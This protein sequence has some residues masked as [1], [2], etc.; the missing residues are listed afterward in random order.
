MAYFGKYETPAELL[1]DESLNKEKKIE[2]LEQW[3]EDEMALKRAA[4]EGMHGGVRA[5]LKKVQKA[6]TSL[7]DTSATD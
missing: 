3:R 6:L 1:S 2:M 7:R 5:E 4:E